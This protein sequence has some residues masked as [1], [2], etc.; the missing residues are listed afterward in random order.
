[1]R[2][3]NLSE[4]ITNEEYII[5]SIN[6]DKA[7]KSRLQVL[8]ILKE[9]KIIILNKRINGLIIKVR[10]TRL[11]LDKEIS[12]LIKIREVRE[13]ERVKPCFYRKS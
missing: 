9:T 13:N 4:G 1:M 12:K 11:G 5:Q 6:V 2:F 10:G 3:I 7:T 8:G